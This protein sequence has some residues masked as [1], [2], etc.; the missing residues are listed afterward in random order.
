MALTAEEFD[1]KYVPLLNR[2]G[3]LIIS[4]ENIPDDVEQSEILSA[5]TLLKTELEQSLNG[6]VTE[7]NE[8]QLKVDA[9][10]KQIRKLQ[11]T[12]Q[13][14][15]LKVGQKVEPPPDPDPK[16]AKLSFAEIRA[17]I[18]NLP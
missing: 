1:Q 9:K 13:A 15:F 16:P 2:A 3:E 6:R 14:L 10:D 4:H 8:L 7:V 5:I 11:E 17:K 12:N 18:D